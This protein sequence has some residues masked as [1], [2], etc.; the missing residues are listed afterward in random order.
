MSAC[1]YRDM[2]ERLIANSLVCHQTGCW[3]WIGRTNEN[4]YPTISMRR[5]GRKQP[6]AVRAH[7]VAYQTLKGPISEGMEID[8]ICRNRRCINPDHLREVTPAENC[9]NRGGRFAA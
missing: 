4:G 8:H 9:A 1:R 6:N 5:P 7:R 3:D 2:E